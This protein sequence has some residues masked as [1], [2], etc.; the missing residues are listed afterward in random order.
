MY[1]RYPN[2]AMTIDAV[3]S[4]T[5]RISITPK[6]LHLVALA[7]LTFHTV[8]NDSSPVV[9]VLNAT[10]LA[11]GTV[12]VDTNNSISGQITFGNATFELIVRFHQAILPL[13]HCS[14]QTE[15]GDFDVH[16][17]EKIVNFVVKDYALPPINDALHNVFTVPIIEGMMHF[18]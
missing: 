8:V 14:Q 3:V 1:A 18:M 4:K 2:A 9:F 5:P 13:T 6:G 10:I 12:S 15:V 17:L 7:N 16:V 11:D